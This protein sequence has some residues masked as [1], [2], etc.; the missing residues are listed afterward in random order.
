[1]N[2]VFDLVFVLQLKKQLGHLKST[3]TLKTLTAREWSYAPQKSS[4]ESIR[5]LVE[6]YSA[7]EAFV[8]AW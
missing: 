3:F 4:N 2:S 5:H 1:M 6:R 8:K 7:K